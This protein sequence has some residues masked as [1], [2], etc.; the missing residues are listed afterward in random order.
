ATAVSVVGRKR[1]SELH[2][3]RGGHA[4][5]VE[6]SRP[7]RRRLDG[8]E[9]GCRLPGGGA[10]AARHVAA[11]QAVPGERDRFPGL[12]AHV[13]LASLVDRSV[14]V[15]IFLCVVAGT[16]LV[17][18][19]SEAPSNTALFTQNLQLL[20]YLAGAMALGLMALIVSPGDEIAALNRLREQHSI[21]EA[22]LL[23]SRGRVIAQS[24]AEPVAL[25]PDLPSPSVLRQVRA[26]QAQ[27]MVESIPDRGLY[28][29]AIVPVN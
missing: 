9:E 13:G 16:A 7:A 21:E 24:G 23:T 3:V 25:L 15:L 5:A 28:L 27:R 6:A 12:D 2:A 20:L 10:H 26:G 29:R 22:T 18:L 14:R 11:A 8:S 1:L 19:M 17:Y 4:G